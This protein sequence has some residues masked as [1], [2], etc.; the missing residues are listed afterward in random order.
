MKE[1]IA[2]MSMIQTLSTHSSSMID[3]AKQLAGWNALQSLLCMS[4]TASAYPYPMLQVSS[5]TID[6]YL[7]IITPQ[8]LCYS[9][10]VT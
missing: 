2:W 1:L 8:T 7:Y 5:M 9:P 4:A 3:V 10:Q 6:A